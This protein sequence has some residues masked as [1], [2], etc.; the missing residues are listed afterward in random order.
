[1]RRPRLL[2]AALVVGLAV[3]PGCAHAPQV[4][5]RQVVIGVGVAVAAGLVIYAMTRSSDNDS[6]G[7]T[8]RANAAR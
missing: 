2:S 5:N 4:T 7:F 1:M 3:G 6:F 8:H